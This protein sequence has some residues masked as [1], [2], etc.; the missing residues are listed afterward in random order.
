[1]EALKNCSQVLFQRSTAAARKIPNVSKVREV[2]HESQESPTGFPEHFCDCHLRFTVTDPEEP[3]RQG[4][5]STAF[6][7]QSAPG[8]R[9][10]LPK[11]EGFADTNGSQ[12]LEPA[13]KVNSNYDHMG[14]SAKQ[15][16]DLGSPGSTQRDL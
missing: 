16:I 7:M 1:M 6:L 2:F 15:E 12:L 3:E 10:K 9:K 13:Q 5:T 14:K 11:S 8:S 4:A